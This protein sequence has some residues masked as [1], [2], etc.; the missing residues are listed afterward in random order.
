MINIL[1]ATTKKMKITASTGQY[2]YFKEDKDQLE[3]LEINYLSRQTECTGFGV[4]TGLTKPCL[5]D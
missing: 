4:K 3:N 5:K 2:L 1:K